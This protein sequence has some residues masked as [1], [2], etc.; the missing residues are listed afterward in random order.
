MKSVSYKINP[1]VFDE[2]LNALF[3]SAWLEHTDTDF[4]FTLERCLLYICASLEDSGEIVGFVKV[5]WDGDV[6]GF[7][8]DTT[9]HSSVQGQGIGRELVLRAASEAR[10]RGIHWLHV[11]FEAHLERFYRSCGFGDTRAGLLRLN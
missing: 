2:D 6:H 11:D 10:A 8:L 1:R 3:R 7:L 5:A 4:G 9:V